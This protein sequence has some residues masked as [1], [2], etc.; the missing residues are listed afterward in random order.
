[1]SDGIG[2]PLDRSPRPREDRLIQQKNMLMEVCEKINNNGSE[3]A[4]LEFK[5]EQAKIEREERQREFEARTLKEAQEREYQLAK[6]ALDRAKD[7]RDREDRIAKEA[8]DRKEREAILAA[9]E[10]SAQLRNQEQMEMMRMIS[11]SNAETMKIVL[12]LV[13]S[14]TQ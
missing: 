11:Q 9:Q 12:A 1:M 13:T 7:D 4:L 8:A 5:R 6:E 2:S 14:K 3:S 10:K